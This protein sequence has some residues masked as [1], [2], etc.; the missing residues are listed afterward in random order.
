MTSN[1]SGQALLSCRAHTDSYLCSY[2]WNTAEG[3]TEYTRLTYGVMFQELALNL[4]SLLAG[5][6]PHK[7]R[8]YVGHDASIIR[9]ISGLGVGKSAA[10]GR[11]RWPALG[12]EV[13]FEVCP[14]AHILLSAYLRLTRS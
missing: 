3:S 5:S 7:A 4:K 9:L 13:V 6:E 12:S 1:T 8:L 2:I 10:D 14:L 11:L